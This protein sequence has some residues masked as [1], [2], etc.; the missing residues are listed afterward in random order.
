VFAVLQ[1]V[2][3]GR[4]SG[5]FAP[6]TF[7]GLS[8]LAILINGLVGT[9]IWSLLVNRVEVLSARLRGVAAGIVAGVVAPVVWITTMVVAFI[10]LRAA[11]VDFTGI[12]ENLTAGLF[13]G[14]LIWAFVGVFVI[15]PLVVPF[16]AVCGWALTH[17]RFSSP[18]A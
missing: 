16:N 13:L 7:W 12:E 6:G 3:L 11:G 5:E 15:A 9:A 8:L 4:L 18:E 1:L 17:E 10:P 14:P 2:S